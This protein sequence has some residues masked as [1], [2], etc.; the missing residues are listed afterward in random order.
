MSVRQVVNQMMTN[1]RPLHSPPNQVQT[2]LSC[3]HGSCKWRSMALGWSSQSQ[4]ALCLCHRDLK[5][6]Q[7][8]IR[9]SVGSFSIPWWSKCFLATTRTEHFW[10]WPENHPI[11]AN[12]NTIAAGVQ[13]P[14]AS[15]STET[16]WWTESL[17]LFLISTQ[18]LTLTPLQWACFQRDKHHVSQHCDSCNDVVYIACDGRR[19]SHFCLE[20]ERICRNAFA[21]GE[22][23]DYCL[24][25]FH[26]F[27]FTHT[28]YGWFV[29]SDVMILY[30]SV[31]EFW[32]FCY[33][34][35]ICYRCF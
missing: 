32:G 23:I 30:L 6:A 28:G 13:L 16:A 11:W 7:T 2:W 35:C 14:P 24:S 29:T 27:H 1:W 31:L 34:C 12:M 17:H 19:F 5:P 3:T 9:F 8:F 20:A 18:L 21:P 22:C 4:S 10:F 15:N 26:T 25:Y 33:F